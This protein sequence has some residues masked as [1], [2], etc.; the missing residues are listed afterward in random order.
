MDYCPIAEA[1]DFPARTT[2]T[3]GDVDLMPGSLVSATSR[4]FA[5]SNLLVTQQSSTQ[6]AI[7]AKVQCDS[8]TET[9]KVR[10][11]G[12]SKWVTCT[13]TVDPSATSPSVFRAGGSIACPPYTDV[14]YDHHTT[15]FPQPPESSSDISSDAS[16]DGS[17][18]G[19]NPGESKDGSASGM[20]PGDSKDGS[21]SDVNRGESETESTLDSP[22]VREDGGDASSTDGSG[23]GFATVSLI[24]PLVLSLL[25]SM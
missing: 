22:D 2:C 7:C 5:A 24:L 11:S 18:S 14:C 20:N 9:Y 12:A 17:A 21:A 3:D 15:L 8:T 6:A 16:K 1:T 13:S 4:C 10:F 23:G 19:M 25:M